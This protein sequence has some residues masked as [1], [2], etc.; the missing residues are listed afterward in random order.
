[1][2]SAN[3]VYQ[4]QG[5]TG[6]EGMTRGELAKRTSLSMATIRYYED[7]GILPVPGR[8]ANGYRIYSEDYL[9]KIP[10]DKE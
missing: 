4:K 10:A 7:S 9:V 8:V 2:T 1:M 3:K 6:M 5:R